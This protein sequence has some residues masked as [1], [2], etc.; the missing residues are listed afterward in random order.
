MTT[1]AL[2]KNLSVCG[3]DG[4]KCTHFISIPFRDESL[5]HSFDAFR[6]DLLENSGKYRLDREI[7]QKTTK[8]HKTIINLNLP[9]K[10]D[11]ELVKKVLQEEKEALKKILDGDDATGKPRKKHVI[12][13]GLK[14]PRNMMRTHSLYANI[15]SP[16][17]NKIMHHLLAALQRSKVK[18]LT[19][20][21]SLPTINQIVVISDNLLTT[22]T[23]VPSKDYTF[24]PGP[25]MSAYKAY[26]FGEF[27]ITEIHLSRRSKYGPDGFYEAE[28]ILEF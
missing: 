21:R 12:I 26:N 27:D 4:N 8:L 16:T 20:A 22:E 5:K 1:E 18:V 10:E 11:V 28:D 19:D 3:S 23:K 25:I 17:I 15:T 7:V 14:Y 6:A 2:F 24:N 9:E 13:K